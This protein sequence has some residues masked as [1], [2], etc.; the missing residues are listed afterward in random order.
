MDERPLGRTGLT[1]P[2]VGMGTWRTFDVRGPAA[3]GQVH[4]IVDE[5][6][7]VGARLLDSSPMYGEAE[8]V[9]GQALVGRRDDALIATKVWARSAA[10]GRAQIE[11][12]PG[13]FGGRVDLYQVHNL[14]AWRTHLPILE[15]VQEEGCVGAI[16]ATHYSAS[17]FPDLAE[18]M[19]T[20]RITAVAIGVG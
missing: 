16:G 13:Y 11:R 1:V 3:E 17:A 9:L 15:H 2:A 12:A 18:V 8:R 10:E 6:L 20:G 14:V 7:T 5:A 19:R 4:A